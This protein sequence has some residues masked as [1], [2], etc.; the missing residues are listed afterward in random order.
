MIQ[1]TNVADSADENLEKSFWY[2]LKSLLGIKGSPD[3]TLELEHEI[4]AYREFVV[5]RATE[6]DRRGDDAPEL[7]RSDWLEE[8]RQQLHSRMRRRRKG[9]GGGRQSKSPFSLF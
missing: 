3:T 7:N 4:Q 8:R 5:F 6:S 9:Y 2:R 1:T